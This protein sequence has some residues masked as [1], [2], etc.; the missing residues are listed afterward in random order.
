MIFNLK[1]YF[2]CEELLQVALL[3]SLLRIDRRSYFEYDASVIGLGTHNQTDTW[4]QTNVLIRRDI[5]IHPKS[6]DFDYENDVFNELNSLG[7]YDHVT[8]SVNLTNLMTYLFN[9]DNATTSHIGEEASSVSVSLPSAAIPSTSG[10]HD[11]TDL[12]QEDLDIIEVLWKHD[13]HSDQ[14]T[15]PKDEDEDDAFNWTDGGQT[16]LSPPDEPYSPSGSRSVASDLFSSTNDHPPHNL[17]TD[18][19][20]EFWN[21]KDHTLLED[22]SAAPWSSDPLWSSSML[23]TSS[24]LDS[25]S[26][27][28]SPLTSVIKTEREEEEEDN[29]YRSESIETDTEVGLLSPPNLDS[30][31]SLQSTLPLIDLNAA[32][33][34]PQLDLWSHSSVSQVSGD[35][36][37]NIKEEEKKEENEDY[38]KETEESDFLESVDT[39][40]LESVDFDFLI[41][42]IHTPQIHHPRPLQS[43]GISPYM[44]S[45]GVEHRWQDFTSGFLPPDTTNHSFHHHH[46]AH[47]YHHSHSM[48]TNYSPPS[49]STAAVAAAYSPH[50]QLQLPSAC[51]SGGE[52]S[53]RNPLLHN[54]AAS[55]C[56]YPTISSAAAAADINASSSY[57]ILNGNCSI[58]TAVTSSM[59]LTSNNMT[60]SIASSDTASTVPFKMETINNSD[61]FKAEPTNQEPYPYQ[62]TNTYGSEMTSHSTEGF[63]STILND[64]D[65]QLMDMAM[66]EG[67]YT[68]RMMDN[69]YSGAPQN[70][71]VERNTDSDSAVSSMGSERVPSL[72]SDT[73]WM[74]TNSDS[75]H[76]T[77]DHYSSS[78]YNGKY[79][80]YD[81][82]MYGPRLHSMGESSSSGLTTTGRMPPVPQKKYQL[83]GRRCFQDQQNNNGFNRFEPVAHNHTYNLPPETIEGEHFMTKPLFK[84]KFKSKSGRKE[85]DHTSRDEKRARGLNIPISVRDIINLP[86]DE[87]NERLSK[88]DLSESQL[89]LIRDIR[90]RG[91]NKVAAQNCR[92]RKMDQIMGLADEVK[93]MKNRKER[94]IQDRDYL[95]VEKQRIQN[96]YGQLYRHVFQ[97]LRDPD[98]NPYSPYEYSLQQSADGSV[99]LVPRNSTLLSPLDLDPSN[100]HNSRTKN[101]DASSKS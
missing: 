99:I 70:N 55:P 2:G 67:M 3:L 23:P 18:V 57:P 30:E 100:H 45:M 91:K 19:N 64:D 52:N 25:N 10:Q 97:S 65:L 94:L 87:F 61:S 76:N 69:G 86:M 4:E 1:K 74:E 82:Y 95:V 34:F 43:R 84:D 41:E 93:D 32:E 40:F 78:D 58:G 38:K 29:G 8:A 51:S 66:N 17:T 7:V 83:Y 90:R 72:S 89:S 24:L 63:L 9:L 73:E 16:T 81:N 42:M 53:A 71:C 15:K 54:N 96:M 35:N 28:D 46:H 33:H 6:I 60:E 12:S 5:R 88:Y 48:G 56:P 37:H 85:E 101:K 22:E 44:R 31:F 79:R 68:M 92:K 13:L 98:G 27:E 26:E 11:P 21:F 50:H 14:P 47:P 75:G 36:N 77:Q 59:H 20:N 49:A 80:W 62:M 39:E